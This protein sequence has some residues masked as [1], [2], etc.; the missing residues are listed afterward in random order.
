MD[1]VLTVGITL[2][3]IKA[4]IHMWI[5]FLDTPIDFFG[6]CISF[7]QLGIFFIA[8]DIVAWFIWNLFCE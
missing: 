8:A 5:E 7:W 3:E 6:W 4:F 1:E 2:N